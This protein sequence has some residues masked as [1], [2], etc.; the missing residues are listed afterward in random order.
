VPIL[1]DGNSNFVVGSNGVTSGG[2]TARDPFVIEGWSIAAAQGQAALEIEHTTAFFIVRNIETLSGS[3]GVYLINANDGSVLNSTLKGTVEAV[4][5]EGSQGVTVSGNTITSGGITVADNDQG[6]ASNNLVISNNMIIDGGISIFSS[7][8]PTNMRVSSNT[9]VDNNYVYLGIGVFAVGATISENHVFGTTEGIVVG[10]SKIGITDNVLQTTSTSI[11][12][13]A[14]STTLSSNTMIGAGIRIEAPAPPYDYSSY[15]DSHAIA[16]NNLVNGKPVLYYSR[17]AGL[18][19]ANEIVGQLMITSC[20]NVR[21]SNVTTVG[22]AGIGILLAYVSQARLV[23]SQI[24]GN[25]DGLI[26]TESVGVNVSDSG[27]AANSCDA[28]RILRST[29]FTLAHSIVSENQ[30]GLYEDSSTNTMINGN[31]F[32]SNNFTGIRLDNAV[33]PVVSQ[34]RI[35]DGRGDG[36]TLVNFV[37]GLI[38]RNWISWNQGAGI[39]V[40]GGNGLNV[41]LNTMIYNGAGISFRDYDYD[42][43]VSFVYN[44]IVYHNNFVYNIADQ[45]DH[46][47]GIVLAWDNG[48]PSGGN[49]WS[50]FTGLDKCSGVNQNICG[51]PDGIGDTPYKGIVQISL[52]YH[53][54]SLSPLSDNYPLIKP[55]GN[56]TQDTKPPEWPKGSSKPPASSSSNASPLNLAWWAQ[57]P[58]WA[59]AV[60]ATSALVVG[61][62]L[63]IRR[64]LV[65]TR[66]KQ[67][68]R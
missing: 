68:P 58:I 45:A 5:V 39:S 17:C 53:Y 34:N 32:A 67:L 7:H 44:T 1:I 57:N 42:T 46:A 6:P 54:R 40:L 2:G 37:G 56:A 18:N 10:G 36:L 19:L 64:R 66:A 26:V 13:G 30:N 20:S 29:N 59:Y 55:F 47:P 14:N 61:S 23:H 27:F 38:E 16:A 3:A 35:Q 11:R 33:N 12:I 41:T 22:K 28:L 52:P 21:V 25:C 51:Q 49:Y 31:L 48:Y 24:S 8:S 65:A 15:Y 4:R 43:G 50:D 9:I 60:A 62:S 63:L